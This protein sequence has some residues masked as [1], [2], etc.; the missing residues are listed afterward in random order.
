[1]AEED[2]SA[3]SLRQKLSESH[4]RQVEFAQRAALAELKVEGAVHIK[5]EDL[6]GVKPEEMFERA[7]SLNEQAEQAG[8]EALASMLQAQGVED[9]DAAVS[10]VLEGGP[11]PDAKPQMDTDAISRARQVG[12]SSGPVRTEDL[13][14][15]GEDGGAQMRHYFS[16]QERKR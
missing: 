2:E 3:S 7:R 14:H 12:A 1:M 5:P 6:K 4:A 10:A 11:A 9:V 15:L 16:E 8:R 13:T